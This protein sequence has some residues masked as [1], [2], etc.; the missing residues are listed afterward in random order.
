MTA[1]LVTVVVPVLDEEQDIAG[2]LQ[3]IAAQDH[4]L[5]RIELLVVDGGSRD[6]TVTIAADI[7]AA[8]PWARAEILANP[9]GRTSEGLNVGLRAA[10][11]EVL[12]RVDARSRIQP[13]HVRTC[14]EVL[15]AR[16]EVGVV[17]GAQVGISRDDSALAVG[18]ARALGNR[19][20]TGLARYRRTAVSGPADTVWMGAFRTEELRGIGGWSPAVALN[21]DFELNQRYRAAGWLVWFDASL[22]SG[23]LPRRSLGGLLRQYF[24]FGRVKGTWWARGRR[25]SGRQVGLLLGPVLGAL[26]FEIGRRRIGS[27]ATV[28]G[29]VAVVAIVDAVGTRGPSVRFVPRLVAMAA[30]VTTCG[31]WW[32]GAVVGVVGEVT[33]VRHR[34]G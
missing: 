29:A 23:Y 10:A 7:V 21:E 34:H 25:P 12:V 15:A 28:V 5:D 3:A 30:M 4:P 22:R 14:V 6:R 18:I 33:G 9:A 27:S 17:G 1:P 26:V 24:F 2:C 13:E 31:A 16:P 8:I 11:G 20:T 19:W 32:T